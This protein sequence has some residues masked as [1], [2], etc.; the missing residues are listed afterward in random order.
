MQKYIISKANNKPWKVCAANIGTVNQ[1]DIF[2]SYSEAQAVC[3]RHNGKPKRMFLSD[4]HVPDS[5]TKRMPNSKKIANAYNYFKNN[6][7]FDTITVVVDKD[8]TLVDGFVSFL[9][10]RLFAVPEVDVLVI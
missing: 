4:I 8:N 6:S 10:F 7:R 2:N 3:N 5:F 9:I 1:G